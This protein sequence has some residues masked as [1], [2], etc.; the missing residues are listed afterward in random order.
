MIEMHVEPR[1]SLVD[2][3]LAIRLTGLA[4]GQ[5]V[6]VWRP[7]GPGLRREAHVRP[8]AERVADLGRESW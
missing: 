1:R 2:E 4:P 8:E 7:D 3:P 5:Q 6:T